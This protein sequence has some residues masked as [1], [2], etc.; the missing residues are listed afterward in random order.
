MGG[1]R[2]STCSVILYGNLHTS[3]EISRE[4]SFLGHLVM[5]NGLK[6][7]PEKLEAVRQMPKP[8]DVEGVRRFCGFVNYLSKFLPRL[9]DVLEPIRQLAREGVPWQWTQAQDQAFQTVQKLVTEA[10][11]LAFYDPSSELTIQCD[12]S[13]KGLGAVLTQN[14]RPIAYASRA[15]T[16][17][18]TRYAQ[19][20]KEML[21]IVFSL[22][23]FHQ[24]AF[25]RH[26]T[27]DSDHKPLEAILR[28]PLANAPR[29]LQ[30][31]MLRIQD[32]DIAVR[33]K[34]GKEMYLADTLSLIHI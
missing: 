34:R 2:L 30:G 23:K 24:Y 33:Y 9:A 8:T 12:S 1:Q 17:T 31:M 29:R 22:D 21:A 7:D 11:V 19:I 14:G 32:Y 18:E 6:I 26:T 10:P 3:C 16:D 5:K 4:I 13:Q 15:L 25:G 27:V 28:K 20:E